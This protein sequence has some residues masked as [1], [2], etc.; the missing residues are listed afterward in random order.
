MAGRL[1]QDMSLSLPA[2]RISCPILHMKAVNS[3]L[4]CA[5]LS[6]CAAT[7]PESPPGMPLDKKLLPGEASEALTAL[8]PSR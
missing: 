5:L 6:A 8:S 3:L 1:P 7:L 2:R 4:A